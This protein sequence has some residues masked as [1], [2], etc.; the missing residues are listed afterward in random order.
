MTGPK[1]GSLARTI[2]LTAILAA[3]GYGANMAALYLTFGVWFIFG[4]VFSILALRL[5]GLAWGLAVA[6]IA[7]SY[8]FTLWS[9]P[10]A[11]IIF[12]AEA[13]WIGVALRRGRRNLLLLDAVYWVVLGMPLVAL[14]YAGVMHLGAQSAGII[15]L[16]QASNGVFNALLAALLLDKT[17]L[18]RLGRPGERQRLPYS[19]SLFHLVAATLMLPCLGLLVLVSRIDLTTA[20]RRIAEELITQAQSTEDVLA[21]WAG[22][23]LRAVAAVAELGS[24]Y[25]IAPSPQLQE[26]LGRLN[27]IF[28]EFHN[29]SL[30]D[31][32]ATT[33]AF[34]PPVNE[35]GEATVGL[36]FADREYF[37][38]MRK[39][40]QPVVSDIFV[41]R[42]G[43][44]APIFTMVFPV[45]DE[46]GLHHFGLG[47]MDVDQIRSLLQTLSDRQDLL[48]TVL[49]R[50]G[51]VVATTVPGRAPLDQP[52]QSD[53]SRKQVA[54]GVFLQVPGNQRNISIVKSWQGAVYTTSGAVPGTPWTLQ[55]DYPVGPLQEYFYR[56]SI[57]SLGIL[58]VLFGIMIPV[59]SVVSHRL[60]RPVQALARITR[61]IPERV[62]RDEEIVW[63]GS[64]IEEVAKLEENFCTTAEALRGRIREARE[65]NLLLEQKVAERTAELQEEQERLANIIAGTDVGTWEWK[66]QDGKLEINQRWAEIIG[67]TRDELEPVSFH[68]WREHSH[69]EDLAEAS[70]RLERHF[71]GES[72]DY[73]CE[74]RMRHKDGHWV[75]VLAR[76][77]VNARAQDGTPTRMSGTHLDITERKVAQQQL[78]A[79]EE[80][81]REMFHR[82]GAIMLLVEP[83]SGALVD[84]NRA[85][86]KFYGIPGE[87]LRRMTIDQINLLDAEQVARE[88][89][90]AQEGHRDCFIFP[91]R[92]AGG[93]IRTVEVHSTPI[94]L[95]SRTLLFSIIHDIT[96]RQQ[97]ETDLKKATREAIAASRAKSEFLANMSHEIRTP[98]NGVIGMAQLLTMTELSEDQRSYVDSLRTSGSN[99]MSLLNG[100]LDLSKIEAGR[101]ELETIGFNL[102]RCIREVALTQ[103]HLLTDKGLDLRIRVDEAI[104][105]VLRGD[106]LRVKQILFNLLGNAT[107]F[108]TSGHVAVEAD[109]VGRPGPGVVVRLA[110][111]DTGIGIARESLDRIFQPFQQ[112]DGSTT[113]R[114]GGTGLGLTICRRLAEIM[115]G[116]ISVEST[117][118]VGSCFQVELPF[119]VDDVQAVQPAPGPFPVPVW[120]RVPLR[121]LYAEVDPLNLAVGSEMLRRLGHTVLTAADLAECSRVVGGE[122]CDLVLLDLDMA[123]AE[124]QDALTSLREG[125]AGTDLRVIVVTAFALRE[126]KSRLL[127]A[128]FD[129]YLSKPLVPEDLVAEMKRVLAL[130]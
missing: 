120:D 58:T 7:S 37:Q 33:V 96:E 128:G 51:R 43:V 117:P 92:A 124:G 4:S 72:A 73:E 116:G 1:S 111:R 130:A 49:D 50:Q 62:D 36:N 68:T 95:Q 56:R 77:K 54:P 2:L 107:K 53:H 29:L 11:V 85:A 83:G 9:H 125:A 23:H 70:E 5:L 119:R 65:A 40:G 84:A 28:P 64:R 15:A 126:E 8:T 106:Q 6:V 82:H 93:Q 80:L 76:G 86:E 79:S 13:A 41:G 121:V 71:R 104:P 3:L 66:V 34:F 101:I 87:D 98:L 114:Y 74:I 118:G 90:A 122:G 108:T 32:T 110:V 30:G 18:G 105:P 14:F 44:F 75:W 24:R 91:H 81:F 103:K 113:R 88:R 16:K 123:A 109:L 69:P 97:M 31:A 21:R 59:A 27:R 55:L 39:T 89:K 47:A 17:P 127:E 129:G 102:E 45:M 57:W 99:L 38:T 10:Y 22:N 12:T 52:A 20:E 26:E 63:P 25:G 19:K 112:G 100:I 46:G 94:R 67:R 78:A 115:G 61:D 60:T 42:G 35:R 48:A